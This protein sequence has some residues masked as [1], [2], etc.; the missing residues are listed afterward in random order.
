MQA[1]FSGQKLKHGSPGSSY[2][3]AVTYG[4]G[5]SGWPRD[6]KAPFASTQNAA[7]Q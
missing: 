1:S 7:G 6:S 3:P 2:N 4:G 5:V